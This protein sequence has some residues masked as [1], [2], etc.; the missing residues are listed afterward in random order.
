M[1]EYTRE[2]GDWEKGRKNVISFI[3]YLQVLFIDYSNTLYYQ[4][5]LLVLLQ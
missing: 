5:R 3:V 2:L 4:I 1:K